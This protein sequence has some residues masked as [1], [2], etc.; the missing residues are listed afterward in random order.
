MGQPDEKPLLE[1]YCRFQGP[2]NRDSQRD[3]H[4]DD[5]VLRFRFFQIRLT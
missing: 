4:I 5:R 1:E 2:Q 3:S